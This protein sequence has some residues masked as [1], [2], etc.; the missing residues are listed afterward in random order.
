MLP[1]TTNNVPLITLVWFKEDYKEQD[2]MQTVKKMLRYS[3]GPY[4]S[5]AITGG[6]AELAWG[7]LLPDK[8]A[9][10]TCWSIYVNNKEL[11]LFEGDMYD[12][13]PSTKLLPGDNP[14]LSKYVADH[15]RKNPALQLKDLNGMYSG[16]YVN[17]D[18][19]CAYIFDDP[20]GTRSVFYLSD[21]RRFVITNNLWAFRGLDGFNRRW[22]KMALTQMLTLGFPM[23]GRTWIE[24]VKQLQAGSQVCSFANGHTSVANML[25]PVERKTWSFE[26]TVTTLREGMDETIHR[27]CR[28]IDSPVG[29]GLSGGLDSRIIIASLHTQKINSHSFTSYHNKKEADNVISTAITRLLG[30]RHSTV[31]LNFKIA[32]SLYRDLRI[33]NEGVSPAYLFFLLAA[34]AQHLTINNLIIGS[35]AIRDTPFGAYWPMSIKSK[36]ELADLILKYSIEFFTPTQTRKI[37]TPSFNVSWQDVLDEWYQ[38]F[39]QIQQDSVFD[40]YI[41]YRINFRYQRR[42]RPRLEAVRWFCQPIYPYMDRQLYNIFRSIPLNHL[43]SERAHLALLC[44]YKTGIEKIPNAARSFANVSIY[45]EYRYSQIVHFGRLMRSKILL[46]FQQKWQ[47]IKGE[48]GF[49]QSAMVPLMEEELNS[50]RQCEALNWPEI[51]KI[52]ERARCGKFV[53][54]SALNKLIDIVVINDFLFGSGLTGDRSLI[55]LKPEREINFVQWKD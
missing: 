10:L 4:G 36:Q 34:E 7:M 8:F 16:C 39:N 25:G 53:N 49:G 5:N 42:T 3:C 55:F 2:A 41:D 50:L 27:I 13:L 1:V 6:D 45:K 40:V 18:R 24:G 48:L 47:K 19:S 26:K 17:P 51:E 38:S 37:L 28:R 31:K 33:I 54:R 21:E 52:V 20:T 14:E 46:P 43:E 11:C 23:A 32:L 29:L 9:P 15:M 44:D 22:D 12:D 35:E 30:E